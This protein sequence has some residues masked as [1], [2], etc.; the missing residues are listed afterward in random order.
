MR[1]APLL[2][3]VTACS[4]DGVFACED[5]DDCAGVSGG[6]CES[7]G[8][9]SFPD[10][11]C[12]SQRRYGE[13]AGDGL[14]G[15]CVDEGGTGTS[16]DDSASATS[17]SASDPVTLSTTDPDTTLDGTTMSIDPDTTTTDDPTSPGDES[18]STGAPIDPDLV[19]WYRFDEGEFAGGVV[20]EIGMHDGACLPD[21]CPAPIPGVIGSAAHFDGIDDIVRVPVTDTL[22][23]GDALTVALWMRVDTIDGQFQSVIARAYLD[24][25]DD[26]FEIGINAS[27]V[28]RWGLSTED[29]VHPNINADAPAVGV[30]IH[31]AGTF[32]AE[33]SRMYVN[34]VLVGE[35]AGGVI[36]QDEHDVTLGAGF[37]NAADANW[38]E[39]AL[40]EVRIYRRA[41]TEDEIAALASP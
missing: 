40:D 1:V 18:S 35:A 34:G 17:P 29:P 23:V 41:L 32:D 9:C 28:M 13:W 37:D 38:L 36:A 30:W 16:T 25:I 10:D 26:T 21:L 33:A 27:G 19:A 3:L 2:A 39:G 5:A 14:A 7:T 4:A 31:V 20:D 11:T 8:W 12:G 22:V 15:A 24:L 6:V